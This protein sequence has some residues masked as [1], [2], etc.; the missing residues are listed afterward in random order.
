MN[1]I[2]ELKNKLLEYK[3]DVNKLL[4]NGSPNFK[5]IDSNKF[6]AKDAVNFN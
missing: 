2:E 4:A 3:V 5:I 1:E 6:K